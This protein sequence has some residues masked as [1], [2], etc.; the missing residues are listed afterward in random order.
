MNTA[1]VHHGVADA[2]SVKLRKPLGQWL[3]SLVA[4]LIKRIKHKLSA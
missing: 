3:I 2:I 4:S 1:P